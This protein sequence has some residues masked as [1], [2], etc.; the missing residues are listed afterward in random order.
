MN[1]TGPN[2]L[3]SNEHSTSE[4]IVHRPKFRPDIE[5]LR[6]I[7]IL[8]VLAYHA[9]VPGFQG[10]YIGVNIFFVLSGYLIT[11]LLLNEAQNTGRIDLVRFYSRRARRLLPALLVVFVVTIAF[12]TLIYAPFEQIDL[13]TAALATA[14]Y[15]SNVHF[16][17]TAVD[18]LGAAP[19]TNP[20]LH[21]WSLSLEEQFYLVWPVFVM[22]AA[23]IF[24][25]KT[26]F[27]QQRKLPPE[28]ANPK[29]S[30]SRVLIWMVS[31]TILS[32][33]LSLHW[34]ETKQSWAFFL[35]P[36]RTW[37]FSMGALGILV[38]PLFQRHSHLRT[39]SGWLG[40]LGIALAATLFNELTP[41]PGFAALLP[42]ISTLLVLRACTTSPPEV[43]SPTLLS[44]FLSW[45]VFQNIG[46]VSYAWYLW[47]WP[48]LVFAQ[49]IAPGSPL[50]VRIGLVL[51]AWLLAE[52]T[53][54]LVENPVRHN[55]FLAKKPIRSFSLGLFITVISIF[56]SVGWMQTAKAQ[57]E[58]PN[59][60]QYT[61]AR[62]DIPIVYQNG[63]HVSFFSD[64]PQLEGC[65]L[66]EP[67]SN[68]DRPAVVLVG[69][70]HAAQWYAPLAQLAETKGWALTSMTKA[71]CPYV[72]IPKFLPV[73]GRDY[74]ECPTW[75]QKTLEAIQTLNPDLVIVTSWT[76]QPFSREEWITGTDRMMEALST[77][78][79]HV[80]ALKDTPSLEFD[81][82]ICLARQDR[83]FF[84][85][86][87]A[88]PCQLK[89]PET[90]EEQVQSANEALTLAADKYENVVLVD[91]NPYVC[92]QAVCDLKRDGLILYRDAH[93]LTEEFSLS[94][95][96][97]MYQ[98]I[99]TAIQQPLKAR[100]PV[101]LSGLGKY[102]Q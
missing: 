86:F 47:H 14:T 88:A 77:N 18:Y 26:L 61:R 43:S 41:F 42:C 6:A 93:H 34:T 27:S 29:I 46:R 91:M 99:I 2:Q 8:L 39:V 30:R 19:E 87:K 58:A 81:A 10:G 101:K 60:L 49:A 50:I 102:S 7:A 76:N 94:L 95:A 28:L 83:W 51:V 37:E 33:L 63:C 5:G 85:K 59:Q 16:A 11:W 62:R 15:L 21:T 100:V 40:I 52:A 4:R 73:L 56:L 79:Q 53:Y 57:A 24:V 3:F 13:A 1:A 75:Q 67:V 20:L 92:D 45:R 89:I 31:I 23:G 82:P 70:S 44:R 32:F 35:S 78:S 74:S 97:S 72:D 22:L 9:R 64:T 80:V 54:G 84:S 38:P 96:E 66:A 36:S 71:A 68:I 12:S 69:D 98:E 55:S 90:P 25:R 48:I 17:Y 65:T